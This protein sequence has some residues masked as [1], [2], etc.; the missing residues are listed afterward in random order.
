MRFLARDLGAC[1]H[2]NLSTTKRLV[3]ERCPGSEAYA[4]DKLDELSDKPGGMKQV[5]LLSPAD[6][7]KVR[8]NE[9]IVVLN[10]L[11]RFVDEVVESKREVTVEDVLEEDPVPEEQEVITNHSLGD[12]VE[13][14]NSSSKVTPSPVPISGTELSLSSGS[15]SQCSQPENID[16]D[17]IE[18]GDF[19]SLMVSERFE[20]KHKNVLRAIKNLEC[21]TEFFELNFELEF[22]P[23][24]TGQ[25]GTRKGK[26][27]RMTR[28]GFTFLVSGFTGK[29]VARYREKYF[30]ALNRMEED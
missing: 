24:P 30:L 9:A 22:Y 4:G 8:C 2:Q 28:D 5:C 26:M 29:K 14:G 27:Y 25:G 19:D 1:L 15:I 3:S 13:Q 7:K 16:S 23:I 10:A 18:R 6:A 20:K 12:E 21:S 17:R 11:G